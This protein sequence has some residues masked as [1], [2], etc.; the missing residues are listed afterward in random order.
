MEVAGTLQLPCRPVAPTGLVDVGHARG[1]CLEP[2]GE[3]RVIHVGVL[4]PVEVLTPTGE[5]VAI[6]GRRPASVVAALALA[7]GAPVSSE[8]LV[9]EVW[10]ADAQPGAVDTLQSYLSRLRRALEPERGAHDAPATLVR[11]S[12]GYRL[13]PRA[14]S[15]DAVTFE[16]EVLEARE[17]VA[18]GDDEAATQRFRCA[19]GRWRGSVAEGADLGERGRAAATRLD[20]LRLSAT[21]ERIAADLSLG[22]HR[23]LAGE[24]EPLVAANPTR[25]R[26]HGLAMLALYR[27]GRQAEALA[28]FR[29]ARTLL[30]DALGM[31]PSRQLHDLHERMLAQDPSLAPPVDD[32]LTDS[33]PRGPGGGRVRATRDPGP[34]RR[35]ADDPPASVAAS[36]V[37]VPGNLPA[38]MVDLVGRDDQ[39]R[40][41]VD[42]LE[43]SRLITLTGAGGCGKTQLG[44]QLARDAASRFAGG[45]WL[46]ELQSVREADGVL[47]SITQVLGVDD[48]PMPD[49]VEDLAARIG[50]RPVLLLI[51]NC[52]HLVDECAAVI[53]DLLRRCPTLQVVATSRQTLDL[54]GELAWRVP[55]LSLPPA[56]ASLDQLGESDAAA[57]FVARA[58]A[59]R[60]GFTPS[61]D[62]AATI[63]AICRELDGIPLAL[64]LAASRLRVLSVEE[65]ADRLDDRFGMLRS[66]RRGV[67]A[68][69]QTLE[70]AIAWS[71]ELLRPPTQQLLARLTVFEGPFT[72]TAAEG[73]CA[74][75]QL[76]AEAVLELLD[77]LVDRSLVQTVGEPIGPARH[78]L[79]QTIRSFAR[80]RLDAP[81]E[82]ALAAAHARWHADLADAAAAELT[83]ADQ[84]RWLNLLHTDHADLRAALTWSLE[85]G[86]VDIALRIV[87]GIWWFWLQFGHAH[88]GAGWLTRVLACID[89]TSDLDRRRLAWATYGAGRL[90]GAEGRTVAA[91]DRLERAERLAE[92]VEDR[93]LMVLARAR[94]AQQR[95]IR[96][97]TDAAA[98]TLAAAQA[99]G[100]EDPWVLAGL[101]DVAGH[102][103]TATGDLTAAAAAFEAS[104]RHYLDADDRWSAC[105]SRLGWAWV[106]RR[107]G[108]VEE[109]LALHG[110][111][112]ATVRELTRSAFDFVGLA[113]DLRGVGAIAS[114]VGRDELALQLCAAS[115]M[116]RTTGEVALTPDERAEVDEVIAQAEQRLGASVAAQVQ[117]TGEALTADGALALAASVV[118]ELAPS[119]APTS[120]G[121]ASPASTAGPS[122]SS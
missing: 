51:D 116:L 62:D 79:L 102:L 70:A 37:E 86:R 113:R 90:D 16:Q 19:L 13:D 12:A 75:P 15:I 82:V 69:H 54:D 21:E 56:D 17:I 85:Q 83:G 121:G 94:L 87:A 35:R 74:D 77:D 67:P 2:E 29:R 8:A 107:Q 31:E 4:G 20:E 88:E 36:A 18:T 27:S 44:L 98:R 101:S 50:G 120:A 59:V 55:S 103:A 22:R 57:L 66:S 65:I 32:L 42:E 10:G 93:D 30:I 114:G 60:P 97:Q 6:G 48:A 61:E 100:S 41:L 89:G 119:A 5:P 53:G 64:E 71:Y 58:A 9:A 99:E 115:E 122:P 63:A 1:R 73:I 11:A 33:A 28:A 68:R 3:Q 110:Q 117:A 45:T 52:E 112:L 24:L 26:L 96:G 106:A 80:S 78:A 95:Q 81:A 47:R 72:V 49:L 40:R 118:E 14:V 109:A 104:E 84:V 7:G 38:A 105:L 46:V 111:N 108:R 23:E 91:L 39:R 43:R 34:P 25:E 92:E 76:P